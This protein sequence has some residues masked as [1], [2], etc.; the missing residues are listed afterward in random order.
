MAS[1]FAVVDYLSI[2]RDLCDAEEL[3]IKSSYSSSLKDTIEKL[4]SGKRCDI[5]EKCFQEVK[6]SVARIR[7]KSSA[8]KEQPHFRSMFL[9]LAQELP[10][11]LKR[12]DMPSRYSDPILW[13]VIHIASYNRWEKICLMILQP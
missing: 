3:K 8:S 6:E 11:L 9:Y 1:G 7:A 5:F 13:Q 10:D 4:C 12:M 2:V